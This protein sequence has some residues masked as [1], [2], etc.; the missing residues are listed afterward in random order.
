M[1]LLKNAK[2]K[3]AITENQLF[4]IID[5]VLFRTTLLNKFPRISAGILLIMILIATASPSV[6][7]ESGNGCLFV[8]ACFSLGGGVLYGLLMALI[9]ALT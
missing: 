8:I 2:N 6:L 1:I 4:K 3:M 9:G 7:S 5:I